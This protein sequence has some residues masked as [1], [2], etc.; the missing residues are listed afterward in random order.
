[1]IVHT[2]GAQV[3]PLVRGLRVVQPRAG[4]QWWE[5]AGQT[6]V[7][8]YRAVSTAGSVWGPGPASLAESYINLANPGTYD[9]APGTAPSFATATGWTFNGITQ[10][11]T[12]G[13]VP[14]KQSWS[15]LIRFSGATS[16]SVAKALAGCGA[17]GAQPIFLLRPFNGLQSNTVFGSGGALVDTQRITS[18]VLGVAGATAYADG[19][20]RGAISSGTGGAIVDALVIGAANRGGTITEYNNVAIQA[21]ALY[22]TTLSAADVAA[23]TIRMNAL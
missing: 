12:T 19:S 15:M 3:I 4:G 22:S 9:A 16:A 5:I 8:I 2:G 18:G 17:N 23:L 7:G 10:H 13:I 14:A 11:L 6:A 21:V 1:M 20:S